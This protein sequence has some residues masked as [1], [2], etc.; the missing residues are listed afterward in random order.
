MLETAYEYL[1]STPPFKN[2]KLPHADEV[3][4]AVMRHRAR[5]AD[6]DRYTR[7]DGHTIRRGDHIIRV[8]AHTVKTTNALIEAMAHEMVHAYQEGVVKTGSYVVVHNAEFKRLA[9]RVCKIHGWDTQAF[10]GPA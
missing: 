1:R 4:F 6:H 2:W 3:E 9:A 5:E 10:I 8:S 7:G